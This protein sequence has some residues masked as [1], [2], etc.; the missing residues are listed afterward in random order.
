MQSTTTKS[1]YFRGIKAALPFVI[2]VAP[3]AMLFGVVA[4]E[5]GLPLIQV[6]AFSALVVAGASH[7]STLAAVV[8]PVARPSSSPPEQAAAIRPTDTRTARVV[9]VRFTVL[10]GGRCALRAADGC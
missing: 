8:V 5:A 6:M 3:F 2:V 10:S 7:D 9:G 1:A 4:T